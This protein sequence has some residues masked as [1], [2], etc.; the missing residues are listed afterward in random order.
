MKITKEDAIRIAIDL[1]N[2]DFPE[3]S[4]SKK[5]V[6]FSKKKEDFYMAMLIFPRLLIIDKSTLKFPVDA[7]K[8]C[9]AHEFA[10]ISIIKRLSLFEK[11]TYFF[12]ILDK[13]RSVDLLVLEK[14]L[15]NELLAF[16]NFHEKKFRKYNK[17]DG[18]T[19]KEIEKILKQEP[20]N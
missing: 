2:S 8:G 4:F 1:R 7:F 10:H 19:R 14:G 16:H 9:L 15:G 12:G 11:V 13:E 3:V 5:R 6:F 18:L 17:K 20:I